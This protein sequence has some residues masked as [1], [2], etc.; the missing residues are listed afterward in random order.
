M[1]KA[2]RRRPENGKAVERML[3]MMSLL[4]RAPA[5]ISTAQVHE[6]LKGLGYEVDRRTVVRDLNKLSVR[7]GF[8]RKGEAEV[9][10]KRTAPSYAWRWPAKCS[11]IGAPAMTEIEALTLTMVREHL[12]ALLPPMVTEALEAQFSRAEERLRKSPA[13]KGSGLRNWASSVHVVQPTQPLLRPHVKHAVRDVIYL[14]LA[15][16]SQFTGWY[17]PRGAERAREMLFNP[18]GL[19]LRGQVTY[20]VASTWEYDDVRLYPLHRFERAVGEDG[21]RRE[22]PGFDLQKYL[23][24]QNGL[25]FATGRGDIRIRLL[26]RDHSGDHLLETPLSNDQVTKE[27]GEGELEVVATIPETSQVV[28]WI[29]GFGEYVEVLE[30][31]ALREQVGRSAEGVVARYHPD[32]AVGSC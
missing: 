14:A 29:L 13:A 8:E 11:G 6:R 1:T 18:L 3:E 15:S 16:R 21:P 17:R 25:G 27:C 10:G 19:V 24:E 4:P 9:D 2:S 26:F 7:F 12:D 28:W 22:P 23:A 32:R 30:P 31:A 20:L 5:W